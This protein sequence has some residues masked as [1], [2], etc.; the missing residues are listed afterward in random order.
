M[1][2]IKNKIKHL[3]ARVAAPVRMILFRERYIRVLEEENTLLRET[4][5]KLE[6]SVLFSV[7]LS[8]KYRAAMLQIQGYMQDMIQAQEGK[9]SSA[10]GYEE[11]YDYSAGEDG[12]SQTEGEEEDYDP[13]SLMRKK[14]ILH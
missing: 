3:Y 4:N 12:E 8:E 14:T 2:K 9:S 11:H 1:V 6:A 5:T 7:S 13:Y 10:G